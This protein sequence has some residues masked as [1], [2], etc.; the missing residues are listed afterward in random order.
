MIKCPLNET[1]VCYDNAQR[2]TKTSKHFDIDKVIEDLEKEP[3]DI[4]KNS[5]KIQVKIHWRLQHEQEH[6]VQNFV[7]QSKEISFDVIHEICSLETLE[8]KQW[9]KKIDWI[10]R[11]FKYEALQTKYSKVLYCRRSQRQLNRLS[12]YMQL[13]TVAMPL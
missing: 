13:Q 5:K 10:F 6:V 2:K 1:K 4:T 11:K 3:E 12:N 8:E 7:I 9:K